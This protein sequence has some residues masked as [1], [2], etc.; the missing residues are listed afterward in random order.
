VWWNGSDEEYRSEELVKTLVIV[1][2]A[3]SN[4]IVSYEGSELNDL[5]NEL[6]RFLLPA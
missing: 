3:W 5:A 6:G 4:E 1:C 2:K